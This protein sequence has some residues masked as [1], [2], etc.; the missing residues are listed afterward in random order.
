MTGVESYDGMIDTGDIDV[1]SFSARAG[2]IISIDVTE[3]TAGSPLTPQLRLYGPNGTLL[4][5]FSGA[6]TAQF[7]NFVAPTNGT[8][9]VVV[10]DFSSGYVGTGTY[11]MTVNGLSDRLKFY[12]PIIA[13]ANVR[14]LSVG[15][16][17]GAP[18]TLLTTTDV[19][20]PLNLWAEL[21]YQFD[22][23]GVADLITTFGSDEPQRFF[24]L[25]LP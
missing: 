24:R 16:L 13:G 1:W 19:S 8:Y 6:A 2:D 12:P 18:F 9:L 22:Q 21:S 4:R 20:V 25:R 14:L 11:R 23:F 5:S 7:A 17:R 3:L 15:G 10:G